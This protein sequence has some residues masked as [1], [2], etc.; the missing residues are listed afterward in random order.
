MSRY[1]NPAMKQLADQQVRYAPVDVRVE[2]MDK[3]ERLLQQLD[4]E[5]P[6]RYQDLCQQITDFKPSMYPD[7]I[8]EGKDA[9]HDLGLFVED[10]S[11]SANLPVEHAAEQVLTVDDVSQKFNVSTKTVDRWRKRGLVGRRFKFGNRTRIGFL[12]SSVDRFVRDHKDEVRRGSRFSQLSDDEREE[13]VRKA[14]RLARYGACPSEVSKRLSKTFD[15][16]PETVRYTLRQYDEQ[17]PENAVFP[18][19]SMPL[20]DVKRREIFKKFKDG[21]KV[22]TLADETCRTRTSIYRIVGEERAQLLFEQPID[23]MDSPEFHKPDAERTILGP[24]PEV[25]KKSG[26]VKPPPGLPPYLASLYSIRCSPA[27]RS[28]ITSAR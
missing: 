9:I 13:M 24:P 11:A 21:V 17:H 16:S 15:R 26:R 28:S 1:H 10:L 4:A 6:Y 2:Q 20:S 3:A 12:S 27:R 8:V 19:A 7:L 23:F 18:H 25:D 22:Q 14:R 5:K